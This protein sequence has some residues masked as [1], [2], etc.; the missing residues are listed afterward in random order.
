MNKYLLV[1]FNF[2]FILLSINVAKAQSQAIQWAS[3]IIESTDN[4]NNPTLKEV[5]GV[6]NVYPLAKE[7][8]Y[9]WIPGY[10]E[11]GGKSNKKAKIKVGFQHASVV[12]Q[13]VVAESYSPGSIS[14]ISLID[15]E[16][17]KHLI[18]ENDRDITPEKSRLTV[19]TVPDF[20]HKASGLELTVDPSRVEGSPCIDAIGI[21]PNNKPFSLAI[22]E[23]S[24]TKFLPKHE[25]LRRA[26]N[27]EFDEYSPVI[28]PDGNTLFFSR[29]G[30]P[31]NIGTEKQ[32]DIWFSSKNE[33]GDWREAQ[34]VREPLN[35][36]D[37]N[38]V[39]SS[40]PGGNTLLLGNLYGLSGE[41]KGEGA[42]ISHKVPG[43]WMAPRNLEIQNFHNDFPYVSFFL[44]NNENVL[45]MAIQNDK[46]IGE[47]DFYVSFLNKNGTWS[48]PANLGPTINTVNSETNLFLAPDNKT[49]YF[50]SNGY[51]GY[52]GF[53]IYMTKRLD[54]SW[55]RWSKP[56]NLGPVINSE[57]D[58]LSFVMTADGQFAYGYKYF[59]KKDSDIYLM[60]LRNNADSIKPES[61][62]IIKG[63]ILNSKNNLPIGSADIHYEV[64][65]SNHEKGTAKA[66]P[67]TADYSIIVSKG[68]HYD[69]IP[70]FPGFISLSDEVEVPNNTTGYTEIKK[71]LYLTP[72][73]V[74]Q[75]IEL[76]K[77]FF[78]QSKDE[79]LPTSFPELD[80]TLAVLKQNP[81][82]VIELR[83][84]TDDTGEPEKNLLLSRHRVEAVKKYLVNKGITA[85]RIKTKAFGETMPVASNESEETRQQNRRVEMMILKI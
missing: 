11:G 58:D 67:T 68:N 77:L 60:D 19:I 39:A 15:Q 36:S 63:K 65:L 47:Q 52:G 64:K 26:V 71:N 50:S 31:Q 34:N 13:V 14:A 21:V 2:I 38:F 8:S 79:L 45:L 25:V 29:S 61:V 4:P 49:L 76:K 57:D 3:Q 81:K 83:G 10:V 75:I 41:N 42:S 53:D 73:E 70:S 56:V 55:K 43:G 54:N 9:A 69:L 23:Y 16:G 28:S 59:D 30:H 62:V 48:E 72:L 17:K 51:L 7:K 6:P 27:S 5:V 74:G 66:H 78:I 22:N 46:S 85:E 12:Q 40:S 24:Q 35:N 18:Y 80:K 32:G 37:H 84:H 44:A 82:M 1:Y 20:R 33:V